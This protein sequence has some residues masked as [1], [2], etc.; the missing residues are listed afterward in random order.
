MKYFL[1]LTLIILATF[2]QSC[3]ERITPKTNDTTEQ[4]S[5]TN[6]EL[7][8]SHSWQYNEVIITGGGKTVVQ[9]SRPN[10]INLS[11][12]FATAK[13]TY[14]S[15]SSRITELNQSITKDKWAFSSDEK[16]LTITGL[17]A[18]KYVFDVIMIS[19]VKFEMSIT[20]KK[21]DF[22][23]DAGWATKMTSLGLPLTSTEYVLTFSSV[24]I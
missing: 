4:G 23:D 17:V 8:T 6:T 21:T 2:L 16:Q 3:D 1:L 10:S 9:F 19:K 13:V 18:G 7:L 5:V 22:K 20:Y 15:D 12:D 14:K 24:P 11:Y